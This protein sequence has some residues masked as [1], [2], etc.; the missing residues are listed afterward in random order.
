MLEKSHRLCD[1]SAL[2]FGSWYHKQ[3]ICESPQSDFETL[4]PDRTVLCSNDYPIKDVTV[5]VRRLRSAFCNYETLPTSRVLTVHPA[6]IKSYGT[7]HGISTVVDKLD[8]RMRHI[9]N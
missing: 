5:G 1:L 9:F 3:K 6:K 8:I 2:T 7:M 4:A